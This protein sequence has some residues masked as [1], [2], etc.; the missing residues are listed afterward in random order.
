MTATV[1]DLLDDAESKLFE[2]TNNHLRKNFDTIDSVLVKTIQRIEDLRHKIQPSDYII[3]VHCASAGEL[4]QGKP[5]IEALKNE[6]PHCKILLSFFSPSGFAAGKKYDQADIISYLPADTSENARKFIEI[7]NPKL[8][9][10][11]KYEYWYHHLSRAAFHHIPI[12]LVS[13]I[14]RK[15]HHKNV[16]NHQ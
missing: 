3:W 11:V 2:I 4:E 12:L 10:F 8:V 5:V 9:V 15:H 7:V 13:S 14:F 16:R 1:F 6:Y